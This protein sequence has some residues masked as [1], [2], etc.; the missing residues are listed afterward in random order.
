M[1]DILILLY[2]ESNFIIPKL[3]LIHTVKI[4]SYSLFSFLLCFH[5]KVNVNIFYKSS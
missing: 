3:K 5:N 1:D 2:N 4:M